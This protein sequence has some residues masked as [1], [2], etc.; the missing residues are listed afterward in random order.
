MSNK[1]YWYMHASF[2]LPALTRSC[3]W[4]GRVWEQNNYLPSPIPWLQA[5]VYLGAASWLANRLESRCESTRFENRAFLAVGR[6][7]IDTPFT[8]KASS[9]YWT[10]CLAEK[11]LCFLKGVVTKNRTL[12]KPSCQVRGMSKRKQVCLLYLYL[13]VCSATRRVPSFVET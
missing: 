5:G 2:G 6:F 10:L 9:G 11:W 7:S 1:S 12:T 8:N 4:I 3:A 13:F